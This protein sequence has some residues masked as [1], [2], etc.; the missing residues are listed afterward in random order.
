MCGIA[1]IL[2]PDPV[3]LTHERL[4]RMTDALAHR[5]PD[6]EGHWIDVTAG[7]GFGHRRLSILD[8]SAAGAQPM[9]CL[10]RYTVIHNGEIYNHEELR[11]ALLSEGY[12]FRSRTDTE[13]IPAAYDRYGPD[14]V[15][16]FEGMFAFALWDAREKI[17]FLARDRFGE[18]PLFLY[19]D[20]TQLLFASEMKALWA[21][22]IEREPNRAMLY[23]FITIGY[24]QNPENPR[25][26]FYNGITRLPARSCL[27]YHYPTG[28]KEITEYWEPP[29][30]APAGDDRR[31]RE[32]FDRLMFSSVGRRLRSD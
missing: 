20:K 25:E 22:G 2:S 15:R 17:L 13:L 24:T 7:I 10:G 19:Q 9:T 21:A 30:A 29:P 12:S 4:K 16:K 1:G 3:K 26:T 27:R 14:C 11:S 31:V 32:E 23:N 5:G 18:K 6:G 8:L 28:K